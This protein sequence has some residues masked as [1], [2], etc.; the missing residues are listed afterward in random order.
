MI[1]FFASIVTKGIDTVTQQQL[2]SIPIAFI[3]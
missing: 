3:L 2:V 1:D